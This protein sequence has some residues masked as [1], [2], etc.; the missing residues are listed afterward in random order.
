MRCGN[1]E[2]WHYCRALDLSTA[3]MCSQR[4]SPADNE[5]GMRRA[6]VWI[7]NETPRRSSTSTHGRRAQQEGASQL[8]SN[9]KPAGE[10]GVVFSKFFVNELRFRI[11]NLAWILK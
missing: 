3:I 8:I 5:R 7:W 4:D 10:Q 11:L 6:G 2:K 1:N 9:F